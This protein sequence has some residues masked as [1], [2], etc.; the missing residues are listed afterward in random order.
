MYP[1]KEPA[2]AIEAEGSEKVITS[3]PIVLLVLSCALTVP[4]PTAASTHRSAVSTSYA[5]AN[6]AVRTQ[7]RPPMVP[8]P[9]EGRRQ[10][11]AQSVGRG[12]GPQG[13]P[14]GSNGQQGY[15]LRGPG[16]HRGDWLRRYGSLPSDQ[17]RKQLE[18]DKDFQGLPSERQQMLRQRLERFSSL[19]PDKRQ[20]V[21]NRM[22]LLEHMPP[23]QQQRVEGL[24]QQFRSLGPDRRQAVVQQLRQL[25]GLPPDQRSKALESGQFKSGFSP[26]EQQ[27]IRGLNEIRVP[28]GAR[29]PGF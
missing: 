22:E 29:G 26:Q 3:H 6:V 7:A 2:Q 9:A 28:P 11:I 18:Q 20:Q 5:R 1:A 16:P 27:I 8:R 24:F 4:L 17:M 15:Q 25:R 14:P 12:P 10:Q 13:P 21:L 19:P 23:E